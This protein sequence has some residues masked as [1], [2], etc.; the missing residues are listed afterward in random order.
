MINNLL[1]AV[2]GSESDLAPPLSPASADGPSSP[3]PF[4]ASA[5]ASES[6]PGENLVSAVGGWIAGVHETIV[7][8]AS[9]GRDA[10][11]SGA[12]AGGGAPP[13]QWKVGGTRARGG[14]PAGGRGYYARRDDAASR[15]QR[16]RAAGEG[17]QS[18]ASSSSPGR[19]RRRTRPPVSSP[20]RTRGYAT[21]P[22]GGG[23]SW[24]RRTS[25]T[26]TRPWTTPRRG[27]A[28]TT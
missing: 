28:T 21:G 20:S 2:A 4:S 11:L 9:S 23:G 14:A 25:R 13:S 26:C 22:T 15:Q 18:S 3:L 1:R 27:W 7:D 17:A 24:A 19:R 12:V 10:V 8:T 5:S 6:L 16:G